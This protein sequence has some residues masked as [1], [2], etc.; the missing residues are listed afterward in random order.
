[1]NLIFRVV[2]YAILVDAL[3]WVL[4]VCLT[5]TGVGHPSEAAE[6][7]GGIT[8]ALLAVIVILGQV[9]KEIDKS[10]DEDDE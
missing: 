5:A 8:L 10:N 1:M 2:G 6:Y 4:L 7:L 9:L 3:L